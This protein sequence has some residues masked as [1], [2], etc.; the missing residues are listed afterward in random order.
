MT[1]SFENLLL[2]TESKEFQFLNEKLIVDFINGLS[3]SQDIQS[4]IKKRTSHSNRFLDA[5]SGKANLRQAHLNDNMIAG[6]TACETWLNELSKNTKEHSAAI[7][8]ISTTLSQTQL[9]LARVADVVVGIRDQ[10]HQLN[11][12]TQALLQDVQSLKITDAADRQLELVFSSWQAGDLKDYSVIEKSYI[13]LD[14]LYWG[15]FSKVMTLSDTDKDDYFKILKNKL[16]IQIQE[17]FGISKKDQIILREDWLSSA[18]K[19]QQNHELVEYMGDWSL[20]KPSVAPNAFLATQWDTLDE[21][22]RLK[23]EI[24][25]L[26][27][28]IATINTVAESMINE[29]FKVR[30]N[31]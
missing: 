2:Q 6:L 9:H 21:Q 29:F 31:G 13:A 3:V 20:K 30:Q 27:F 1:T 4:V 19:N 10:V 22:E 8:H 11:M 5:L 17:D 12:H 18:N 7:S 26:P 23:P 28:H 24:E 25:H 14:N 16:I 15:N